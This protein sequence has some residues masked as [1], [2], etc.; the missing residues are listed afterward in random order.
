VAEASFGHG[1]DITALQDLEIA[2]ANA[3]LIAS[4]PELLK[5]CETAAEALDGDGIPAT[6]ERGLI[7][8]ACLKDAIAKAKGVQ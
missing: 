1:P 6:E 2:H 3:R 5:A 4:A 8:L 7:I